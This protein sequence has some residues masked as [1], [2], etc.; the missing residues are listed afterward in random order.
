M[1]YLELVAATQGSR[2]T[3]CYVVLTLLCPPGTTI[4]LFIAETELAIRWAR[5][6]AAAVV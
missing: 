1:R 2:R 3:G 5:S 6:L 4:A